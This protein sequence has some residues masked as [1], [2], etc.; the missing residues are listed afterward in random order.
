MNIIFNFVSLKIQKE[1]KTAVDRWNAGHPGQRFLIEGYPVIEHLDM[2]QR[3]YHEKKE[4]EKLE[5]VC[6]TRL[7]NLRQVA[8]ICLVFVANGEKESTRS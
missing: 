7:R 1:I 2:I 4:K 6:E 5:K 3:D 8:K